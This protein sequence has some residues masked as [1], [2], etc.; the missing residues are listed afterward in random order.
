MPWHHFIQLMCD[1]DDHNG[2]N[3]S[4]E[5][6]SYHP[7]F[8]VLSAVVQ[9]EL[10]LMIHCLPYEAGNRKATGVSLPNHS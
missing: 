2:L 5:L 9:A 3:P 7:D 10:L 4:D 8:R 1:P 6:C